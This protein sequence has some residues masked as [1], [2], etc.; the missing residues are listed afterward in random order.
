VWAP[1]GLGPFAELTGIDAS[2]P[3][4]AALLSKA[5]EARPTG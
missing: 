5:Q 2:T 1:G 4:L 3:L